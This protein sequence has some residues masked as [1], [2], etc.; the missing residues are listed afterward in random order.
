[1]PA[2][3][4]ETATPLTGATNA[5]AVKSDAAPRRRHRGLALVSILLLLV[6]AGL[7]VYYLSAVYR[8]R[9]ALRAIEALD[10]GPA[11]VHLNWCLRVWPED[12]DLRL[13]AAQVARRGGDLSAAGEL[14]QACERVAITPAT[15]FERAMLQAQSGEFDR[16][17]P[18]LQD[19]ALQGGAN[20]VLAYEALAQGYL[21]TQQ[22]LVA[23]RCAEEILRQQPD[24]FLALLWRGQALE[25][26]HPSEEAAADYRRALELRPTADE[27]RLRLANLLARLG[28]PGEALG[29]F[30]YL[31]ARQP[32]NPDVL[33]GLALCRH[34]FG[35]VSDAEQL[36]D[37]ALEIEPDNIRGLTERGLLALR[38]GQRERA[39]Q[40]LR[41]AVAVAP[42]DR[43]ANYALCNCLR[44]QNREAEAA[45]Y[46]NRGCGV[47][48]DYVRTRQ[49]IE[50]VG[51]APNDPSLRY[52][53]AMKYLARGQE[54]P[55]LQWLRSALQVDPGH[56]PSR[57]ALAAHEQRAKVAAGI[58]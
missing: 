43:F 10:F 11:Q 54:A 41:R 12:G 2:P 48:A 40:W 33:L 19:R 55:A 23:H 46:L 26:D 58:P 35:D 25:G 37:A 50:R 42:D 30:E 32:R 49:L 17:F 51:D 31:R 15:A 4:H 22:W 52:E 47:E 3:L 34:D 21:K 28:Q 13:L 5:P 16:V 18:A 44:A 20:S 14:L 27:A 45:A 39:E 1:M 24:H 6:I 57:A 36:L 29:H 38:Q 9:A 56:T 53:I 7:P 8:H